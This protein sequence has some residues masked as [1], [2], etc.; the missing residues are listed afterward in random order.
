MN[1]ADAFHRTVFDAP[2]GAESLA[3]RLGMSAQVLRN[4]ANPNIPTNHPT[5]SDIERVMMFT[6]D[7]QVLIELAA[8]LGHACHKVSDTTPACDMAVL[9]L[10]TKVWVTNGDVG[11]AVTETLADGRVEK[12]EL[13]KVRQSV[14]RTTSALMEM[15]SRLEGMVEK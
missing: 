14:Y 1:V 2:G 6:G 3:P 11:S 4:K 10:V 8:N 15:L 12:H 7:Y 13:V 9:E 5:L